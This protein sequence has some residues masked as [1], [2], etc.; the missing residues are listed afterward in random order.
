MRRHPFVHMKA[1]MRI[2]SRKQREAARRL[3]V[4]HMWAERIR[5]EP[6]TN[7]ARSALYEQRVR[8]YKSLIGG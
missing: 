8:R 4:A 6:Y 5:M 7:M 3:H 2:L 1:A